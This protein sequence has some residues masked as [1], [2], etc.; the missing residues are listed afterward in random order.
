MKFLLSSLLT[1][2][3]I[4][5][6]MLS[7]A[8]S[9]A[10]SETLNSSI[11]KSGLYERLPQIFVEQLS[12]L[13]GQTDA[14]FTATLSS[15]L[16]NDPTVVYLRDMIEK[17]N[18]DLFDYLEGKTDVLPGVSLPEKAPSDSFWGAAV[19]PML[20]VY[21]ISQKVE[22]PP[23]AA[24]NLES[25]KQGYK[26]F[27]LSPL[28]LG[29]LALALMAILALLGK[30]WAHRARLAGKPVLS[31]SIFGLVFYFVVVALLPKLPTLQ[32]PIIPPQ[33]QFIEGP[34]LSFVAAFLEVF[35]SYLGPLYGGMLVVGIS[36]LVGSR[37]LPKKEVAA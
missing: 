17:F 15:R 14:K 32:I 30:D 19:Q 10:N 26:W 34:L 23:E 22:F 21:G 35:N 9:S 18:T 1:S 27:K 11:V 6:V 31:A 13:Y 25:V 16:K 33:A 36:L 8:V 2:V 12:Q 4:S 20:K 24:A 5:A 3:L 7:A 28:L 37:F 29:A